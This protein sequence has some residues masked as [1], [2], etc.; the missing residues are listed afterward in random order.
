M[1]QTL[2]V[3][4]VQPKESKFLE[5]NTLELILYHI[6]PHIFDNNTPPPGVDAVVSSSTPQVSS[7]GGPSSSDAEARKNLRGSK[8]LPQK[9]TRV[10][11]EWEKVGRKENTLKHIDIYI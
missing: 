9:K 2:W 8:G 6:Y 3:E 5:K 1:L 7:S 10:R 4:H 11:V